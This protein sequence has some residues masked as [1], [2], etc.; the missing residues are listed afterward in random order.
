MVKTMTPS[1][2]LLSKYTVR[3]KEIT[4]AVTHKQLFRRRRC[5]L[6]ISIGNPMFRG[7]YF[8]V[9]LHWI[10]AN[11]DACMIVIGDYLQR[12]NEHIFY[13]RSSEDAIRQALA[14]GDQ[15]LMENSRCLSAMPPGQFQISRWNSYLDSPEYRNAR[16]I[17]DR[18]FL[19]SYE[20]RASLDRTSAGFISRQM[21][22]KKAPAVDRQTAIA[23]STQYLLEEIAVFA[24]LVER[25]WTVEVYPGSEIPVLLD[26]AKGKFA[27]I[28]EF[29]K[30]RMN[31]ELEIKKRN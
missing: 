24:V 21:K 18:L 14:L 2:E 23:L 6:G 31:V 1:K 16:S 19:D 26:I 17:L 12:F 5:Y 8:E 9:L 11:F 4:P 28:P 13:G 3:I 29:L 10:S 20:F 25:G 7:D 27:H 15:F 22:H 30:Q